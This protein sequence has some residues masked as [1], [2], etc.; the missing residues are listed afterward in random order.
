MNWDAVGALGQVVGALAVVITLVYLASQVRENAR[1]VRRGAT[2]EAIAAYR[3]W[4]QQIIADPLM[5]HILIKGLRGIETL[6][7]DELTRVWG[8]AINL[9]KTAENLHFQYASG[10][11]DLN[12]WTGWEYLLNGLLTT[13][14]CQQLYRQRRRAFSTSFQDWMDNRVADTE[15]KPLGIQLEATAEPA[16]E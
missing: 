5:N 9:F 15:F 2:A 10:A 13:T 4:N 1:G 3:Q 8:M 16:G 6:S 14:G 12:V 11:M 7:E